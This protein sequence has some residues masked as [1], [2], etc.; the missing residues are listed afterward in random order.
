MEAVTKGIQISGSLSPLRVFI[1]GQ[2][3]TKELVPS[4]CSPF[5]VKFNGNEIETQGAPGIFYSEGIQT[6]EKNELTLR[7]GKNCSQ[8]RFTLPLA[9]FEK[10]FY[11][12]AYLDGK[13][14]PTSWPIKLKGKKDPDVSIKLDQ[15][16]LTDED[17][18]HTLSPGKNVVTGVLRDDKG[19]ETPL[20]LKFFLE[21]KQ[22]KKDGAG[23]K[24]NLKQTSPKE[25]LAIGQVNPEQELFLN[26]EKIDVEDDGSFE[27]EIPLSMGENNLEFKTGDLLVEKQFIRALEED[28]PWPVL[29]E[30][31]YFGLAPIFVHGHDSTVSD[32]RV[33]PGFMGK[34]FYG[35]K[36][37]EYFFRHLDN[38][39]D[40]QRDM[41]KPSVILQRHMAIGGLKLFPYQK[42]F[43]FGVGLSFGTQQ[44]QTDKKRE[45]FL[46][47]NVIGRVGWM[48]SFSRRWSSITSFSPFIAIPIGDQWERFG[49]EFVPASLVYAF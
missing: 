40:V 49:F 38:E 25:V 4:A 37:W 9:F 21:I 8:L 42:A 14:S 28:K 22:F 41:N 2:E 5:A 7:K 33:K 31:S 1:N 32:F 45:T 46:D 12:E 30:G 19:K 26:E 3:R 6:Q 34:I 17:F 16:I 23:L 48:Y 15:G 35:T 27:K 13:N 24:L 39:D 11:E 18:S 10:G 36:N 44:R 43:H 20:N 47:L 29:P